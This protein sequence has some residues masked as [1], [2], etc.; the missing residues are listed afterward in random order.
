MDEDL[1]E[2]FSAGLAG[3]DPRE[4]VLGYLMVEGS[5]ILA[6]DVSFEHRRVFVLAAGKAAGAMANAADELL[7]SRISGGLVVTKDGHQAG[8][9]ERLE[10]LSSPPAD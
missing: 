5:R 6:G 8:P 7:K 3:A 4:A 2:I 10:T 1:R 9:P